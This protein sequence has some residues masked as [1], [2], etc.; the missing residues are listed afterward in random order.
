MEGKAV[1]EVEAPALFEVTASSQLIHRYVTWVRTMLRDS[2]ANTKN[3][4]EVSGGGRKPWKQKGTG[5]ARIGSTRAPHWRKGGVVFGPT[6]D[7]NWHTRMPR[8]ERRKALFGVYTAKAAE[9][10]VV[11]LESLS[12]ETPK[13]KSVLALVDAVPG[14]VGKKVL[15]IHD[16]YDATVFRSTNNLAY[17]TSRTVQAVNVIDLLN[18][19]VILFTKAS[20]AEL[21]RHHGVG[22]IAEEQVSE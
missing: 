14:L 6:S 8:T 18:N 12:F 16:Q 22:E 7:R 3:R 4:G 5:R 21:D 1:G 15:H 17:V 9:N 20:L 19:D 11:V 10:A 13:T 2:I